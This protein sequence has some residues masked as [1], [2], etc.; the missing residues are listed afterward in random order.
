MKKGHKQETGFAG[1]KLYPS[2]DFS[3]GWLWSPRKSSMENSKQE[4]NP[5]TSQFLPLYSWLLSLLQVFTFPCYPLQMY[6]REGMGLR[7]WI[8]LCVFIKN[9]IAKDVLCS[10]GHSSVNFWV[11]FS[12]TLKKILSSP[13]R[14]HLI[15]NAPPCWTELLFST[16]LGLQWLLCI[17]SPQG[18]WEGLGTRRQPCRRI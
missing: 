16:Y 17:Q 4:K 2:L 12:R 13:L 7:A 10:I 15:E 11:K 9:Q 18:Q 3:L 8:S 5:A 1:N 14:F 6:S